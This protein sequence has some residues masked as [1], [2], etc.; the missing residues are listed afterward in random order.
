MHILFVHQNFPA[1]FGHVAAHLA[2]HAG[3]PLHVRLRE[4]AADASARSSGSSTGCDGG[5]TRARRITVSRTFENAIWHAH[6]RSSR[7]PKARPDIRP[8]LIVGHRGFGSTLFLRELPRRADRQLFRV[9]LPPAAT[10]TWT[11]APTSRTPSINRLRAAARNAM[12]LL[13]LENCDARLQPDAPGSATCLPGGV[14]RQD[15]TSSSTASTPT[16]GIPRDDR[17]AGSA[18]LDLPPRRRRSSPTSTRGMESMRGFDIFMRSPGGLPPPEPT[19]CS[20][21]SARTASATAATRR[22]TGIDDLQGVGA[23]ARRLRPSRFLFTGLVPTGRAGAALPSHRPARL[24]DRAV[25]A[26]VVAAE[27]AGLRVRR[28]W[29]PT[30]SPLPRSSPTGPTACSATSSTSTAWSRRPGESWTPPATSRTW[31]EPA[32]D[33]PAAIQPRGLPPP[34]DDDVRARVGRLSFPRKPRR[35]VAMTEPSPRPRH[36]QDF[37]NGL[38]VK[39]RTPFGRWIERACTVAACRVAEPGARTPT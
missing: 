17:P 14:P 22:C 5:A 8:D 11:S 24:L 16:S 13:D 2:S 15:P 30:P 33:G 4:A 9:L 6:A 3:R 18:N 25:R 23:G 28:C 19:W 27:R 36:V 21:S 7:R 31:A 32:R 1:Q 34:D 20:S 10:P 26:V 37:L 35:R 29:P 39:A 12:I 38:V